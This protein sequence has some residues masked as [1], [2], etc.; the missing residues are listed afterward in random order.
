[1]NRLWGTLAFRFAFGYWVLFFAAMAIIAGT[2]YFGTVDLQE[3]RINNALA[4]T[5]ARLSRAFEDRGSAGLSEEIQELLTDN[6]DQDT[7]SYLLLDAQGRVLAGNLQPWSE[8]GL[9]FDRLIERHVLR[10]GKPSFSRLLLHR[11]PDGT[12]VVV[13]RDM[14]DQVQSRNLVLTALALGGVASLLVA[15]GGAVLFRRRLEDSIALIR[16]TASAIE[17]GDLSRRIPLSGP[18][19][20]FVRLNR[21]INQMLDRIEHLVNGIKDVSNAIAHDLRTPLGRIRARLDENLRRDPGRE[22]LTDAMQSAIDDV[23][24]LIATLNRLL[25]IAEAESGASRQSFAMVDLSTVATDVQELY[26]AAAEAQGIVLVAQTA[27]A[28]AILGDRH[29]IFSAVANLVDNAIKYTGTGATVMIETAFDRGT[30][31]VSVRDDGPGIPAGERANVVRRFY[32]LDP[33]RS[34]PGNG[35]GLS[36]VSA[37]AILHRGKLVLEDG[38]PG[39]VAR[40]VLP[41][42]EGDGAASDGHTGAI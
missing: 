41:L 24:N 28:P 9:P 27:P 1:M 42:A 15:G 37:V 36:I 23:D 20:E 35:L 26:D 12:V 22:Q 11:L 17:A 32:R 40:I 14:D 21:S 10:Y 38:H 3:R 18:E 33:S 34:Q 7:E 31:T 25:Q 5:A 39:L 29:L 16:R 6:I 13:G 4:A 2:V 19:D 30:S 8:A